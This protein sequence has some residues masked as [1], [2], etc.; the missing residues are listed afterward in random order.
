MPSKK[1]WKARAKA[2]EAELARIKSETP[3]GGIFRGI[4]F[5]MPKPNECY[6]GDPHPKRIRLRLSNRSDF[7][8]N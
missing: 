3:L 1:E 7:V 5:P 2:A 6:V 4:S 8:N